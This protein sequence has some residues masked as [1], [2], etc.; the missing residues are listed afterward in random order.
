MQNQPPDARVL[1]GVRGKD[2]GWR[3]LE[4][5]YGGF[6]PYC[7]LAFVFLTFSLALCPLSTF[8]SFSFCALTPRLFSLG[9]STSSLPRVGWWFPC[10][11]CVLAWFGGLGLLPPPSWRLRARA[12]PVRRLSGGRRHGAHQERGR[13][14]RGGRRRRRRG[15][16]ARPR[17]ELR[18]GLQKLSLEASLTRPKPAK[19]KVLSAIFPGSVSN[20]LQP[21]LFFSQ[22]NLL[23]SPIMRVVYTRCA[24]VQ[25]TDPCVRPGTEE[26]DQKESLTPCFNSLPPWWSWHRRCCW[27]RG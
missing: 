12:P 20:F 16:R 6:E 4:F 26:N 22:E 27:G 14:R 15:R 11:V 18:G 5:F 25:T 13:P 7:R 9:S 23:V 21:P 10:V 8:A 3:P 17:R 1:R 19:P 2:W 24:G